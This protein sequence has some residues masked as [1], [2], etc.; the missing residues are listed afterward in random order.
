MKEKISKVTI[1]P[2]KILQKIATHTDRILPFLFR[3]WCEFWMNCKK[4]NSRD[5]RTF[6]TLQIT[7]VKIRNDPALK[8]SYLDKIF[9]SIKQKSI[10]IVYIK[11]GFRDCYHFNRLFLYALLYK[12]VLFSIVIVKIYRI[13]RLTT[14]DKIL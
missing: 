1:N 14:Y 10:F 5:L 12:L 11:I 3:N 6:C 9:E 13:Y 2:K 7:R 8:I 4:K